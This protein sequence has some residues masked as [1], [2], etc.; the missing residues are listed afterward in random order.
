MRVKV[1]VCVYV[2][3][4]VC[5]YGD[6]LCRLVRRST[7]PLSDGMSISGRVE[8]RQAAVLQ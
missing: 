1:Y 2:C 5:M 3:V 4:C 8:F 6:D 7:G